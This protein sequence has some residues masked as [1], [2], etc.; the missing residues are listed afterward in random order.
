MNK[1]NVNRIAVEGFTLSWKNGRCEV[2]YALHGSKLCFYR[3][4][5]EHISGMGYVGY[6]DEENVGNPGNEKE[7]FVLKRSEMQVRSHL[8]GQFNTLYKPYRRRRDV[9]MPAIETDRKVIVKNM[10]A[11][12][13]YTFAFRIG[14]KFS[15]SLGDNVSWSMKLDGG[16]SLD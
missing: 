13:A 9:K 8:N 15:Y 2:T 11:E 12:K 4:F 6:N 7:P 5:D 16:S 10:E 3:V 1:S 14:K